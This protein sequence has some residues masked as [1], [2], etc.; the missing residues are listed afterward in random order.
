MPKFPIS[1]SNST[2]FV[3]SLEKEAPNEPAPPAAVLNACG[4]GK[5]QYWKT[6]RSRSVSLDQCSA[7]SQSVRPKFWGWFPMASLVDDPA[8]VVGINLPAKELSEG[9][10]TRA[11]VYPPPS[12]HDARNNTFGANPLPFDAKRVRG[13]FVLEAMRAE[14][15]QRLFFV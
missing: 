10:P 8:D 15:D 6:W 11:F 7:A 9:T 2:K 5:T 12:N 4:L 3:Q 13:N 1:W 14:G